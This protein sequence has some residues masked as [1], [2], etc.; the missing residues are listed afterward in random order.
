MKIDEIASA[1]YGI[2]A[3]K[4][5]KVFSILY[6]GMVAEENKRFTRLGKRIKRLGMHMLLVER[7]DVDYAANFMRNMKWREIDVMCRERGF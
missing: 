4:F 2:H 5:A 6:M 1:N 7:Q 3:L